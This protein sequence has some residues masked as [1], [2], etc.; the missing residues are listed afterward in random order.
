MSR[1]CLIAFLA[2]LTLTAPA[3]RAEVRLGD[4]VHIGGHDVSHLTFDRHRRA[5]FYLYDGQPHT[6]GCAW[7]RNEDGS[8]TKVCRYKI[9]H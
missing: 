6:A 8:Q 5:V 2:A 9:L 1:Q 3:A 7:R 4:T